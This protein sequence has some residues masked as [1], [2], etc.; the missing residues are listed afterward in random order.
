[1][2]KDKLKYF[3]RLSKIS[4]DS[5]SLSDFRDKEDEIKL[6][7]DVSASRLSRIEEQD[8]LGSESD[9][10]AIEEEEEG[11]EDEEK[12]NKDEFELEIKEGKEVNS[13]NFYDIINNLV[14][15]IGPASFPFAA[16]LNEINSHI[17][18]YEQRS[19]TKIRDIVNFVEKNSNLNIPLKNSIDGNDKYVFNNYQSLKGTFYGNIDY[20]KGNTIDSKMNESNAVYVFGVQINVFSAF[21]NNYE[22]A[23]SA[24]VSGSE[25]IRK[26]FGKSSGEKVGPNNISIF[27][28][29]LYIL[30]SIFRHINN[31]S[32][33][34]GAKF[35]TPK[36]QKTKSVKKIKDNSKKDNQTDLGSPSEKAESAVYVLGVSSDSFGFTQRDSN[37]L[38]IDHE[39][40]A[41][42]GDGFYFSLNLNDGAKPLSKEEV[43]TQLIRQNSVVFADMLSGDN[44]EEPTEADNAKIY[45][46][47]VTM[48]YLEVFK[49][50]GSS[51]IKFKFPQP[52]AYLLGQGSGLDNYESS[53]FIK[54][55]G[56]SGTNIMINASEEKGYI[57]KLADTVSQTKY[58]VKVDGKS[59]NMSVAQIYMARQSGKKVKVLGMY[60]LYEDVKKWDP[61]KKR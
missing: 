57:E 35:Q 34:Y 39:T 50:L 21:Y 46:T 43:E 6:E 13:D 49:D 42:K 56:E 61:R 51:Q 17:K 45:V 47:L 15:H 14:T 33:D 32:F 55:K 7:S 44:S 31:S 28:E 59:K 40:V 36:V 9:S 54:I 11:L 12:E 27:L 10:D 16:S 20:L 8:R 19:Y 5:S 24:Y 58:K 53:P 22:K 1:M 18:I 60:S 2:R 23:A 25:A 38:L 3:K 37:S 30:I 29:N 26:R 52:F 41:S 4:E 48:K